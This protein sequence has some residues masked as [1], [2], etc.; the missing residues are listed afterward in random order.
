VAYPP[1]AKGDLEKAPVLREIG[2][3][4]GKTASQ[5]ALRWL[6]Q[7]EIAA[8]PKASSLKHL[9]ANLD[10]FDFRLSKEEMGRIGKLDMGCHYCAPLVI[11]YMD[12]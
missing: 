8:I 11:P 10:V 12:D 1:L 9:K 4:H 2:R 7:Q 6:V 5:V 3:A